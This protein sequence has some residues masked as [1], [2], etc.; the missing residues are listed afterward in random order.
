M[1]MNVLYLV[2]MQS[3]IFRGPKAPQA[4]LFENII[5]N[6]KKCSKGDRV[7]K[8]LALLCPWTSNTFEHPTYRPLAEAETLLIHQIH[9]T[10]PLVL[11]E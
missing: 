2:G 6:N 1:Y 3:C 11:R 10:P 7:G 9:N 8:T 5:Y 4:V